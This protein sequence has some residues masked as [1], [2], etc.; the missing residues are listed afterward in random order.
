MKMKF[1][2]FWIL[3]ASLAAF[4]SCS[5]DE[6]VGVSEYTL[7]LNAPAGLDGVELSGVTVT[8]KN[9]NTGRES[10]GSD[11]VDNR[12][13]MTVQEGVYNISVNGDV[14]YILDGKEI[15]AKT[16]GYKETV[17]ILGQNAAGTLDLFLLTEKS[18]FVIEEIFFTG[19][20]TPEG[21]QYNGDKYFKIYN[22]SDSVLYA[23]GLTIVESAFLTI[24]KYEYTPDIMSSALAVKALYSV[25]GKGRD[26]PVQPGASIVICDNAIDHTRANPNSIDMSG[27]DFEWYDES[28]NANVTDIDNPAVSN[29]D[30]IYCYTKTIWGP[31]NQGF[32]SYA[33]ARLEVD[34]DVYLTDY[35][36][37]YEYT[38]IVNGVSYPMSGSAY[39]IPNGWIIDAVNLSVGDGY[40][41][42]VTDP[43]LDMGWTYCGK[44]EKDNNRYG[45][46]VRRKVLS[47][48]AG[49]RKILKDTNNSTADFDAAVKPSLMK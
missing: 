47:T 39:K 7:T 45:K 12:I 15:Q 17:S 31:H 3:L 20:L 30:K 19:T 4:Y 1:F 6:V 16:G 41:W 40:E 44:M 46:S 27:A 10:A 48:T 18:G 13:T 33:L 35:K 36:Y 37:D 2:S 24:T 21:K 26:V 42:I 49:G 22:N 14:K 11:V 28:S 23:D 34:K 8:L 38:T 9:I 25:P 5:D 32:N 29:M 43:S